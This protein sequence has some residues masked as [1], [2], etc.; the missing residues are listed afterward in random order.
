M[1]SVEFF[2]TRELGPKDWGTELLVADTS[3]YIGKVMW[4]KAGHGGP[5]QFHRKKDEAFY[6]FSGKALLTYHD[7]FGV[8]RTKELLPGAAVHI[9]PG[10]VHQVQAIEDCVMFETSNPVFEDRVPVAVEGVPV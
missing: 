3:Q 10:A 7:A 6:L 1:P 5:L 4:M 9:P 8:T 2:T